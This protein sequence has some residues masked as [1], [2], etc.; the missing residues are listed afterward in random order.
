M[1]ANSYILSASSN[2]WKRE[3]ENHRHKII[4]LEKQLDAKQAL[5]LEIECMRGALEVIK[6]MEDDNTH[7]NTKERV[8]A[9]S[10]DLLEKEEELENLE[11]LNQ[12]LM[13]KER[14]T[15][16]ELQDAR[17]ELIKVSLFSLLL[18]THKVA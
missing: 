15:N 11:S 4:E 10:V 5:Q 13:V 14:K 17:K 18:I 6:H 9:I 2:K 8:N 12:T 3:K 1:C 7:T 16:D